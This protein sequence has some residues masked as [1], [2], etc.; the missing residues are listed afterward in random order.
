MAFRIRPFYNIH[1]AV[2]RGRA[3]RRD[4]VMLVQLL[5][6]D[7]FKHPGLLKLKTPPNALMINGS[8]DAL[9][10]QW[11]VAFQ[12]GY[13]QQ[14]AG[15]FVVDGVIDKVP[16]YSSQQTSNTHTFYSLALLNNNYGSF[17]AELYSHIWDDP[18]CPQPLKAA[19]LN[20][21]Q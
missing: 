18:R 6:D 15:S 4:D 13:K 1:S 10:E 12:T 9:L 16:G 11:I 2:G 14:I 21:I 20:N 19:L 5:L 3:T 8:D 7:I 17:N